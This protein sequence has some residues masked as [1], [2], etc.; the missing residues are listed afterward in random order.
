MMKLFYAIRKVSFAQFYSAKV[1]QTN[2]PDGSNNFLTT[3]TFHRT[4]MRK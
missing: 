4:A 2:L 3:A 1:P